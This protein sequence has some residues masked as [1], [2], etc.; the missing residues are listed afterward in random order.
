M[1][2]LLQMIN[3]GQTN[4]VGMQGQTAPSLP[5]SVSVIPPPGIQ[6]STS[7]GVKDIDDLLIRGFGQL[8]IVILLI[9]CY[10]KML[11]IAVLRG[12]V[13]RFH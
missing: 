11:Q 5:N 10:L 3:A 1:D 6:L 8:L 4:A 9:R 7:M 13:K 2:S 12:M